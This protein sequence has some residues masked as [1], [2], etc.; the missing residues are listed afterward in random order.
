MNKEKA[1]TRMGMMGEMMKNMM[2]ES[3]GMPDM[4]M[5]M[6]KQMTGT[7]EE[8][9]NIMFFA[10][11]EIRGLFEEWVKVLEEEI[12]A[13]VK[14]KQKTSLSDIAAKLKISEESAVFFIGKL[15]RE[16]KLTLGE[17]RVVI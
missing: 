14:E 10:T 1:D 3:G 7:M 12:I 16:H 17:I 6:M 4:C 11:P 8:T 13:F 15:A 5:G 2:S 9:A